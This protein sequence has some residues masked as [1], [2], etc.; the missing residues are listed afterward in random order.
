M[1]ITKDSMV[2]LHYTLHDAEGTELDSSVGKEPLQYI[3]GNGML[4]PG[5]EAQMEG[6][7]AVAKLHAVVEA[8]QAYGEYN[9]KMVVEVPRSNFEDGTPVEVGMQFQASTV[10]GQVC[11]VRVI[12][13]TDE[14]VTVDANH[15]LAGKQLTFDV[16]ILE[17]R[18]ATEDELNGLGGCG[19]CDG[20]GGSWG[21]DC[22]CEGGCEGG[23]G[24]CN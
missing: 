13:V 22:N 1:K 18:E 5:L 15:E 23:C 11:L 24:N 19:G 12:A 14:I 3:H 21:G 8:A 16:E 7:E 6:L 10:D 4:I 9:D 20:C 17:V 2:T